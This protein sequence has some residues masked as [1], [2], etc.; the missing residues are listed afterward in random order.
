MFTHITSDCP[1]QSWNISQLSIASMAKKDESN[2]SSWLVIATTIFFVW[3]LIFAGLRTWT[4][5]KKAF[6]LNDAFF[7]SALVSLIV[8]LGGCH[9]HPLNS[10]AGKAAQADTCTGTRDRTIN[11]R[12]H[13]GFSQLR[14]HDECKRRFRQVSDAE[15]SQNTLSL[16]TQQHLIEIRHYTRANCSMS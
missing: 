16:R 3:A 15:G 7:V 6:Q 8:R 1:S 12:I 13:C 11:Q 10:T 14:P 9:I 4:K 5:V 2:Y